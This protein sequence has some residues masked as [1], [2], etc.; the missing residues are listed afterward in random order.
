MT[1]DRSSWLPPG[2]SLDDHLHALQECTTSPVSESVLPSIIALGAHPE[3]GIGASHPSLQTLSARLH[4]APGCVVSVHA[5]EL[6][7][8]MAGYYIVYPLSAAAAD[9]VLTCQTTSAKG[10]VPADLVPRRADAAGYYVSMIWSSREGNSSSLVIASLVED[11]FQIDQQRAS[12]SVLFARPASPGGRIL[13]TRYGFNPI[14][15][16]QSEVWVRTIK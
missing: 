13:M 2:I 5:G 9:R 4:A 12:P 6:P 7:S 16:E 15:E 10:L 1:A 3:R 8:E 14:D 11:L